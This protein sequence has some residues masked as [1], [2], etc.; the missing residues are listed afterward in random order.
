MDDRS[1][2]NLVIRHLSGEASP[3]EEEALR[4]WVGGDPQRVRW[5]ESLRGIWSA[6]EER[7]ERFDA[8][9][10]WRRFEARID[11][12]HRPEIA[13][14]WSR[15]RGASTAPARIRRWPGLLA[16]AAAIALIAGPALVWRGGVDIWPGSAEVALEEVVTARGHR[17]QIRLSDGSR[18][19]LGPDSRLRA[20]RRFNGKSRVVHLD[21]IAEFDVAEDQGRP[22]EVHAA[23]TVTRV[24]GTRFVVRAYD[25]DAVEVAVA[26]GRVAVQV[27]GQPD[28]QAVELGAGSLGRIGSRGT[29]VEMVPAADLDAF[30]GW[31]T[32][33]LA[34]RNARLAEALSDIER[35]Y[36]TEV[37][38]AD[39]AMERRH[40]TITIDNLPLDQVLDLIAL[41]LDASYERDGRAFILLPRRAGR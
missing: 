15:R 1:P 9:A 10:A 27:D 20:P 19:L 17:S 6:A 36:D 30:F 35:W 31:T 34:F 28:P 25:D 41:S 32:G 39:P 2:W 40:I 5:L 29:T 26:E 38:V 7:P 16:A 11:P 33:R 4:A 21:G 18:V 12:G 13:S 14:R 3:E 24:L 22:F 8:E 37:R 23:G